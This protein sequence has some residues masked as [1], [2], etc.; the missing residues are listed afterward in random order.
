MIRQV[1]YAQTCGQCC[2]ATIRN[3]SLEEAIKLIGHD[4]STKSKELTKLFNSGSIKRGLPKE[5]GLC[6]LKHPEWKRNFHWILKIGDRIYDPLV[7]GMMNLDRYFKMKK[8]FKV[9]SHFP[10]L[11][12]KHENVDR[13]DGLDECL[14][15]GV[16]NY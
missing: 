15:C 4:K 5:N 14:D 8:D 3:I 16:R 6:M 9:T 11:P 12:C 13:Q 7:G 1:K 10:I 2:I